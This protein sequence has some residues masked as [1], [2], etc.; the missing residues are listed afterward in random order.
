MNSYVQTALGI[1]NEFKNKNHQI[2]HFLKLMNILL[3]K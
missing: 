3:H 2:R 1:L